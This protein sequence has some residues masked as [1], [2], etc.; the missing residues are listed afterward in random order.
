MK[1]PLLYLSLLSLSIAFSSLNFITPA[2]A[3]TDQSSSDLGTWQNKDE[4]VD[5]VPDELDDYPFDNSRSKFIEVQDSEPND[6]PSV[7][8]PLAAGIPFR[9]KG[10]ISNK[11]DN[12]DLYRFQGKEG[13]FVSALVTYESESFAPKAYFSDESGLAINSSLIHS[14]KENKTFF[15]TVIIPKDGLFHLGVIDSSSGGNPSFKYQVDVFYDK[16][17]DGIPDNKERALG[18]LPESQDTDEDGNPDFYEYY[19]DASIGLDLDA[20][21]IVNMLDEDSDGDTINDKLDGYTDP[22]KDGI[23]NFTDLDSDGDSI[24]DSQEKVNDKGTP[25][26]SDYDG[27]ADFLDL[28]NDGDY[29]LDI[30]DSAPYV[31]V[32]SISMDSTPLIQ[33]SSVSSL[34]NGVTTKEVLR[35][36]DVVVVNGMNMQSAKAPLLVIYSQDNIYNFTPTFIEG[37]YRFKLNIPEGKHRAFLYVDDL[38]TNDIY[39][40]VYGK[41]APLILGTSFVMLKRGANFTLNVTGATQATKVILNGKTIVPNNISVA[42]ITFHVPNKAVKGALHLLNDSGKSNSILYDFK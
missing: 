11:G 30:H 27:L 33:I 18:V 38:K 14:S 36:N 10:A 35:G 5:G 31:K 15:V 32:E 40:K 39:I 41:D 22:D 8:T 4:D 19:V 7:A 24:L 3:K 25:L 26:D 2:H 29:I 17:I 1:I 12:G 16:D 21:C 6:N 28:D 37:K 20:D 9:V 42:S 23:Y 34:I 13:D